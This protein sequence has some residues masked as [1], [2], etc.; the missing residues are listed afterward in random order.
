MKQ[1]YDHA[2]SVKHTASSA[3][4]KNKLKEK[5]KTTSAALTSSPAVQVAAHPW[6]P[7]LEQRSLREFLLLC[8]RVNGESHEARVSGRWRR[9]V[10]D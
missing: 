3:E 1:T 9:S 8:G 4:T 10:S 7:D 6:H 5:T 2:G